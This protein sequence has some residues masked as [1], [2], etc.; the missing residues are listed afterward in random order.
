MLLENDSSKIFSAPKNISECVGND[1]SRALIKTWAL[2]W[3]RDKPQKPLLIY[4]PSGVGKSTLANA[5][6]NEMNWPLFNL[7]FTVEIDIIKLKQQLL[8]SSQS[9]GLFSKYRLFL[10]EDI[11]GPLSR[12]IMPVLISLAKEVKQPTIFI[13]NDAWDTKLSSLRTLCK[14][15]ELKKIN[16][17][18]ISKILQLVASKLSITLSQDLISQIS[19]NSNGD[20]RAAIIDLQSEQASLRDTESD[21]F[22]TVSKIF[23]SSDISQSMQAADT[24]DIDL[25]L[26]IKWL[27]ENLPDEYEQIE[28]V[29]IGFNWLSKADVFNGRILK[30]QQWGLFVYYRFLSIAGVTVAKKKPYFKFIKYRFPTYIKSLSTSR[31]KRNALNEAAL[32]FSTLLH[33]SKSQALESLFYLPITAQI[34]AQNG[35]SPDSISEL[36]F[37]IGEEKT[38][39]RIKKQPG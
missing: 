15:V 23:K 36:S 33:C 26:L 24:V 31:A 16:S 21:V 25:P 10:I 19:K 22:K 5:I 6:S 39:K 8:A 4:G 7:D 29:A 2:E 11:D 1:E 9:V 35:V 12:G 14:M 37:L 38:T 28:E 32:S 20:L 18:S 17:S 3:Q 30:R 13:A 34:L 27:E